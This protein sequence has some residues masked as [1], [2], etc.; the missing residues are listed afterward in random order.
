MLI[1]DGLSKRYDMGPNRDKRSAGGPS[2]LRDAVSHKWRGVR[3]A[4]R[5]TRDDRPRQRNEFWAL[6]DVSFEVGRSEVVGIV[7]RN[8]AGKSTLL[9]FEIREPL[10]SPFLTFYLQNFDGTQVLFSDVRDTDES[11]HER[12]G[13]GRH[14]FDIKLPPRLL[15]PLT[16]VLTV[17]SVMRFSGSVDLRESCC[18]FSLSD[19][20][21]RLVASGRSSILGVLLPWEHRRAALNSPAERNPVCL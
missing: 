13:M 12:L 17:D 3:D 11:V 19:L 10:P 21:T 6:R 2:S 5:G 1:C 4:L 15:A 7:G 20:S 16:L 14:T 9:K 18:E 8:G